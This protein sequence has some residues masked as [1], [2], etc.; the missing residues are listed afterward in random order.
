MKRRVVTKE[1]GTNLNLQVAQRECIEQNA[2]KEKFNKIISD[3]RLRL[4]NERIASGELDPKDKYSEETTRRVARDVMNAPHVKRLLAEQRERQAAGM[5]VAE[6]LPVTSASDFHNYGIQPSLLDDNN[7]EG[8]E[9][10]TGDD[11]GDNNG[12]GEEWNT[13]DDDGAGDEEQE[14][15]DEQEQD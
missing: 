3:E 2:R 11:D 8:E 14:E 5:M 9:Q 13:G 7:G 4:L 6:Y 10:N 15:E 12:E 1:E